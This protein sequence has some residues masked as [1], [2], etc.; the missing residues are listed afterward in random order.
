MLLNIRIHLRFL[1]FRKKCLLQF[2][3]LLL[4][5]ATSTWMHLCHDVTPFE[6]SIPK[7]CLILLC[8]WF[9]LEPIGS[10]ARLPTNS[11]GRMKKVKTVLWRF[12]QSLP[13]PKFLNFFLLLINFPLL[14]HPA[15]RGS[16]LGSCVAGDA[17]ATTVVCFPLLSVACV[18]VWVSLSARAR[19]R[20]FSCL[21][22]VNICLTFRAVTSDLR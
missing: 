17:S 7:T 12:I 11:T 9:P 5:Q 20:V 1:H 10:L 16:T 2:L 19:A 14:P 18:R 15:Y 6:Q 8:H 22:N 4:L 21:T 13:N 3:T